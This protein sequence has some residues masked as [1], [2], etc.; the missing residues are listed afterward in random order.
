MKKERQAGE[1]RTF[2]RITP[3]SGG[4]RAYPTPKRARRRTGLVLF[5]GLVVIGLLG[6]HLRQVQADSLTIKEYQVKAA[7]LYNFAKFIQWPANAFPDEY[8]PICIGTLG[9]D[10]FGAVLDGLAAKTVQGRPLEIR[11]FARIQ[12]IDFCHILFINPAEHE[13]LFVLLATLEGR[14][15]LTVSEIDQFAQAGGMVNFVV[16]DKKI[17]FEINPLS[18][19]Q[20]GLKI[21]SKLLQLATIIEAN[22]PL[23]SPSLGGRAEYPIQAIAR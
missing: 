22:P 5:S 11:R 6:T 3:G 15:M 12:D 7:F 20:A 17:R 18:A 23:Q 1:E 8:T 13:Q 21:S 16:R 2:C 10:P 4:S 9:H 14:S 19:E